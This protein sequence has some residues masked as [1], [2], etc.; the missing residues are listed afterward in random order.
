[1]SHNKDFPLLSGSFKRPRIESLTELI[2]TS[3]KFFIIKISEGSFKNIS[4]FLI[5]KALQSY[6]G[7]LENVKKQRDG[8]LLIEV[9]NERQSQKA[10]QM[11]KLHT[12]NV[13]TSP[14]PSLNYLKGIITCSDFSNCTEEEILENLKTQGV[15]SVRRMISKR[16]VRRSPP[17]II[18]LLSRYIIYLLDSSL[19]GIP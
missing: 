13:I 6:F 11:T 15:I 9:S 7:C 10:L 16:K 1:M 4:P 14:H 18:F 5:H 12:Y 17:I 2:Q 19:V 3:D 8:S